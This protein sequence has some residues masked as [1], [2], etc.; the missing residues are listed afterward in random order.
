[1]F[2]LLTGFTRG[3]FS[4]QSFC[5]IVACLVCGASRALTAERPLTDFVDADAGICVEIRDL[6]TNLPRVLNSTW[7]QRISQLSFIRK[8]QQ[9][10][11][12]AKWQV[13]KTGLEIMAGQPLDQ[14][15]SELFGETVLLAISPAQDAGTQPVT[16]LLS[17]AEKE[18]S[19]DKVLRLWDQLE[20][21]D[22]QTQS[23]F[24]R[25]VQRRQKKLDG[26]PIGTS[27]FTARIG[28]V[29]AISESEEAIRRVLEKAQ[30][31]IESNRA[32]TL[33]HSTRHQQAM[34]ALNDG[35]AIRVVLNPHVWD[36]EFL[37]SPSD[38][39]AKSMW[40][41]LDW[42]ALGLEINDGILIQSVARH[43]TSNLPDEWL[44]LV[45]AS[46]GNRDLAARLPA[47]SLIAG[48]LRLDSTLVK[49]LR[50]VD[51]S[52][53]AQRD[54]QTLVNISKGLLDRDLFT[55]V[56]PALGPSFGVAVVPSQ[57]LTEHEAPV[58]G[59]LVTSLAEEPVAST[60]GTAQSL[61][62]SLDVALLTLW[63]F[64]TV[65]H[66]SRNLQMPIVLKTENNSRQT[67]RWIEGL[68]PYRPA[69]GLLPGSLVFASDP[70]LIRDFGTATA[71][72]SL[73]TESRFA[74]ARTRHFSDHGHWLFVNTSAASRFLMEHHDSLAQQLAH[75]RK[76]E[77]ERASDYLKRLQE[78]LSPFD[79]I[80]LASRL[81][82]GEIRF[83]AGFT[84]ELAAP[85][86]SR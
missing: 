20:T 14:F 57:E 38:E 85:A 77:V 37:K 25:S 84:S 80:F 11:E 49:W 66:N 31:S 29:L 40:R 33:S 19:W 56:L 39:L 76:L 63:N 9:S 30:A 62:E 78:T 54:W 4:S 64:G 82:D 17:R 50:T 16:V 34:S 59:L 26:H 48:E 43:S 8:W 12:F 71:A 27:V 24:G 32:S 47:N 7:F 52:E 68:T 42:F 60:D 75:W 55:D 13:G 2:S 1:M 22:V 45:S 36:A 15:V 83:T 79:S 18:E 81:T 3:R 41:R 51:S 10:P 67:L 6:K 23:V 46:Q 72:N 35:C 53:R 5:L 69:Y 58:D 86:Q 28:R 70:R 65:S 44:R 61:R 73:S 74:T 21:H